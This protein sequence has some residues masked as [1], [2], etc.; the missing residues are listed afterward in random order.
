MY[1]SVEEMAEDYVS[2][3]QTK[4]PGGP[5][6]LGGWS[7]G[8][9]VAFEMAN[10]LIAH[11]EKVAGVLLF[12]PPRPVTTKRRLVGR[13]QRWAARWRYRLAQSSP[14]LALL[15]PGTRAKLEGLRAQAPLLRLV[16]FLQNLAYVGAD[17]RPTFID[18]LFPN[19]LSKGDLANLA[20]DILWERIHERL[21]ADATEGIDTSLGVP[22]TTITSV[23]RR[24]RV[25]GL[26]HRIEASYV[27]R[28]VFP[29]ALTMFLVKGNTES[30]IWESFAAQPCTVEEFDVKPTRTLP[31]HNA[32]M[33][34]S[35][36]DL[37]AASVQAFLARTR[38]S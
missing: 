22:G 16:N 24:A 14:K 8:A 25:F 37:F 11:G 2:V 3:L 20:P 18:E 32:M 38:G 12:D 21:K 5:Y 31:A 4:H 34:E 36:V 7:L 35:N 28:A 33:Q 10:R 27:P 17:D 15:T 1:A 13:L 30:R 9:T 6:R 23:R 26:E 19:V 29:G